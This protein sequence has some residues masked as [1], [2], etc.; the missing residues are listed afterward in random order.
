MKYTKIGR[1]TVHSTLKIDEIRLEGEESRRFVPSPSGYLKRGYAPQE[2][3]T[4]SFTR[5][6]LLVLVLYVN[7]NF[8][9]KTFQGRPDLALVMR[10]LPAQSEPIDPLLRYLKCR[11]CSATMK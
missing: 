9:F 11:G 2:A 4:K 6:H 1:P 3:R 10:S 5:K 8:Q 7:M